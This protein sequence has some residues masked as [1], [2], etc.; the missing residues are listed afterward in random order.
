[1]SEWLVGLQCEGVVVATWDD[2]LVEG[3]WYVEVEEQVKKGNGKK[4]KSKAMY[5]A[6][7]ALRCKTKDEVEA[8]RRSARLDNMDNG[9]IG[10]DKEDGDNG[11]GGGDGDGDKGGGGGEPPIPNPPTPDMESDSGGPWAGQGQG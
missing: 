3:V 11:V 8:Y 1:M 10:D 4:R 5:R 9:D 6:A 2:G 7:S